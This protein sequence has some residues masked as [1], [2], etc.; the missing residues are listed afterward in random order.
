MIDLTSLIILFQIWNGC[1][2]KYFIT[3][4]QWFLP[5]L[6]EKGI[7]EKNNKMILVEKNVLRNVLCLVSPTYVL[8]YTE[9]HSNV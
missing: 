7:N 3:N 6:T 4:D 2:G 8:C 5:R 1:Y 9:S